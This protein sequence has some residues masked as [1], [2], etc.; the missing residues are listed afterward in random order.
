MVVETKY[1]DALGVQP[2]ASPD[3]LKK[4][5]KKMALKYHPD[6][7]PN[8]AEKFKS[9]SQ[10]YEVLS[11]STKR[12]LYD[13]GG[14]QAI[15]QGGIDAGFHDPSDVF[16]MFFGG[17]P[18]QTSNRKRCT[19]DRIQ[20]V[21]V[22]L[23]EFYNGST[24][25]FKVSRRVICKE[26]NGVGG[27]SGAVDQCIMCKG[28]G[29]RVQ[30]VQLGPGMIQQLC[31]TCNNCAGTGQLIREQD[32]CK[33]CHAQKVVQE[34]TLVRIEILKGSRNKQQIVKTG[35]SDQSPS[36]E[37][38]DLVFVLIE[39][40]H[41]I[42]TR[43]GDDLIMSMNI[44]LRE[45]LTGMSRTIQTLDDRI[46]HIQTKPGEVIAPGVA[47]SIYNEGMPRKSN[48]FEKGLMIVVFEVEFPPSN[49]IGASQ[50]MELGELLPKQRVTNV[51]NSS[52]SVTLSPYTKSSESNSNNRGDSDEEDT[53]G[54]GENLHQAQCRGH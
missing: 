26:C 8:G 4:A 53:N 47:K 24:R 21:E 52:I 38:G 48:S 10:A 30:I 41:P 22:S 42:F 12:S 45:A 2:D 1:Y 17:N 50:I 49:W 13:Q 15:K 9:I 40:P 37:T 31:S 33:T 14:E 18:F 39:K 6:K 16:Q 19:E 44:N 3:E 46:L 20:K 5:Y 43:R 36:C 34:K 23:Q 7:N 32:K 35:Y 25:E 54:H 11:D 28:T 29:K 27:K 51:P